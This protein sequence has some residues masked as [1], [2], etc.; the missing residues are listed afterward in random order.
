MENSPV[1]YSIASIKKQYLTAERPVQVIYAVIR[2][3]ISEQI[4]VGLGGKSIAKT[5][6]LLDVSVEELFNKK[7]LEFV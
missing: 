4:S 2:P 1:L 6:K 3:E 5:S 7:F